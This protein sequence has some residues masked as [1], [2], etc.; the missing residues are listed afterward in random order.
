MDVGFTG[1]QEGMTLAQKELTLRRLRTLLDGTPRNQLAAH[2]GIC[3]GAD[4][5]FHYAC[6]ALEIPIIGH[7]PI[8]QS[9][10]EKLDGFLYLW[11]PKE[12]LDRN[13]DIVNCS[14]LLIATPKEMQ[15]VLR[16]GT[17]STIRKAR[18][19]GIQRY[20]ILPNGEVID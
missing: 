17:W 14:D 1:T 7:P 12:Y 6:Q 10:M 18:K 16:S 5:H 20:I 9:K 4:A 3:I 11:D 15:E 8:N 2:H 13:T 19:R